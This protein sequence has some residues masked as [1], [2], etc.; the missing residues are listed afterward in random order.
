MITANLNLI[1]QA[2]V[3][4]MVPHSKTLRTPAKFVFVK[5]G[6]SPVIGR[7]ATLLLAGADEKILSISKKSYSL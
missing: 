1:L 2:T 4:L 7:L 6:A 5:E 3:S